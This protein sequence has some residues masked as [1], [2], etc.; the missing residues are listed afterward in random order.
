[1]KRTFLFAAATGLALAVIAPADAKT[2]TA[3]AVHVSY[4]DLDL[5]T[6]DGNARLLHRIQLAAERVCDVNHGPQPLTWRIA[7]DRCVNQ[8]MDRAVADVNSPMLTA[9]HEGRTAPVI[10]AAR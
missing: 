3:H 4:R 1:M 8:T 10:V 2:T 9:M 7:S 6:T 5:S